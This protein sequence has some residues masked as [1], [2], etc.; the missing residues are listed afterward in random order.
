MKFRKILMTMA[1][2]LTAAFTASAADTTT[3][4]KAQKNS[5]FFAK[6]AYQRKVNTENSQKSLEQKPEKA[7]GAKAIRT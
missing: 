7:L 3:S 2:M 4:C 5:G 1:V 6:T